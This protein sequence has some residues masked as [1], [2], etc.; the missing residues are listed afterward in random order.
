MNKY[1][2]WTKDEVKKMIDLWESKTVEE[3]CVELNRVPSSVITMAKQIREA[4]YHLSKKRKVSV[5]R[6]M[7]EETLKELGLI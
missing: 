1:K 3:L 7:V 4:G 2:M 6:L 5:K